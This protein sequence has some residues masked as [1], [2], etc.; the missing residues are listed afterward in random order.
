MTGQDSRSYN[1]PG[2]IIVLHILHQFIWNVKTVKMN[3]TINRYG[4]IT[5]NI[6]VEKLREK[7]NSENLGINGMLA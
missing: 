7:K 1:K 3:R 6:S 5:G 2:K 4:K